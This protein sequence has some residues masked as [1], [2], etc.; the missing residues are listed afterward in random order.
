MNQ[1][2][3]LSSPHMG[4]NEQKYIDSAFK[5]NWIAPL[6][7]N[8]TEFENTVKNYVQVEQ[9]YSWKR[10]IR[11]TFSINRMWVSEGDIVLCSSLTFCATSNPILYQKR[12]QYL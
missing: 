2:I 10:D 1:T 5:Q 7:E 12:H 8:V 6:G 4:G 3:Y 11:F 9:L